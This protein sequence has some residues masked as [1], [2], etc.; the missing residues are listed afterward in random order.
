MNSQPYFKKISNMPVVTIGAIPNLSRK[1]SQ[2]ATNLK[3]MHNSQKQMQKASHAIPDRQLA[4][5][6][7]TMSSTQ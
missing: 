4:K 3:I 5:S 2:Q 1:S 6:T 7:L